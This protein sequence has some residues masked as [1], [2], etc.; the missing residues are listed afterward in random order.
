MLHFSNL[1]SISTFI[2]SPRLNRNLNIKHFQIQ[3]YPHKMSL[4][5]QL[6][7]NFTV[8]FL[9]LSVV[10]KLVSFFSQSCKDDYTLIAKKIALKNIKWSTSFFNVENSVVYLLLWFF[11]RETTI[12][13]YQFLTEKKQGYLIHVKLDEIC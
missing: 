10:S 11:N 13:T 12:E 1:S 6:F 3:S 4:Q 5:R 9:V 8:W 7:G 2:S